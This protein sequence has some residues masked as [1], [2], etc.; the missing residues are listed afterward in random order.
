MKQ[1]EETTHK[2]AICC[3]TRVLPS[4]CDHD[5]EFRLAEFE[6]SIQYQ[7]IFGDSLVRITTVHV[8]DIHGK[9]CTRCGHG[10]H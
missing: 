3:Q 2:V 5:W 6:F 8:G 4:H 9:N 7:C 1:R 10:N